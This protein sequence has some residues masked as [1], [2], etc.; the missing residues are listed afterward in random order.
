M[1]SQYAKPLCDD[2]MLSP[3][4]PER[5]GATVTTGAGVDAHPGSYR[6]A[7]FVDDDALFGTRV[8]KGSAMEAAP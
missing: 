6:I 8:A 3:H 7:V 2:I 1:R 4:P 5:T